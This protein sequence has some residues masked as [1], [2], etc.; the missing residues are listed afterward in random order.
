MSTTFRRATLALTVALALA[1]L[2]PA[3]AIAVPA[4]TFSTRWGTTGAG[5]G[6]FSGPNLIA[7]D[8]LGHVFVADTSNNRIQKFSSAG[9]FDSSWVCTSTLNFPDGVATD[10]Y[11][12]VYVSEA[13]GQHVHRFS[14]DGNYA[15]QIGLGGGA[16]PGQFGTPTGVAVDPW[17]F[18]YVAD[19]TAN[20][21]QVFAPDGTYVSQFG[22]GLLSAPTGIAIDPLGNI[23]VADT[24]HFRVVEFGPAGN[25]IRAFGS[26]GSG[27]GQFHAPRGLAFSADGNL[28]VTDQ[29]NGT[30]QA[31]STRGVYQYSFGQGGSIGQN[32]VGPFGIA[33]DGTGIFVADIGDNS[34]KKFT[35]GAPKPVMRIGGANRF[36][37]AVNVAAAR[38]PRWSGMRHVI[39]VNG[40]DYA[41]ANALAVSPL[42]GVYNAPILL[43]TKGSLPSITNTALKQMRRASGPLAI[44]VIGDTRLVSRAAYNRIK[45]DNRGGSVERINGHDPYT[46]SIG[47]AKRVKSVTDSRGT[48]SRYVM[49]FNAQRPSAFLDALFAGP[50]AARSGIPMLAVKNTSVPLAVTRALTTTFATR[51]KLVVNSASYVPNAIYTQV[52]ATV[53]LSNHGDH[54]SSAAD[55]SMISRD[56][57]LT[58]WDSVGAVSTVPAALVAGPYEGLQNGVL[59]FTRKTVWPTANTTFFAFANSHSSVLNGQVFGS[60][61]EITGGTKWHFGFDLNTP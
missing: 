50:A 14:S 21:V 38:W 29:T 27:P 46:L 33:T 53:R 58:S 23:F 41:A 17:E 52:G 49:V 34:M 40:E 7:A 18:V 56:G 61:N 20:R 22:N 8:R 36:A 55:I 16:G 51:E 26:L 54:A 13:G 24:G 2:I 47:I 3:M 10:R 59:L 48:S 37:L 15:G 25:F 4:P 39:I 43:T 44:H 35:F 32:T 5:N 28:L 42:A 12:L 11:G 31:F 60:A 45:A 19:Q 30:V 6:D 57:A 1:L 9:V